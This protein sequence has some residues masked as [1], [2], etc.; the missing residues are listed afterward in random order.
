[1]KLAIENLTLYAFST[2]NWNRPKIEVDTL[3][4]IQKKK[5]PLENNIKL[6]TIGN[7]EKLPQSAQKRAT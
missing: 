5:L 3:M 1:M 6:N 2:E 4:I 7:L